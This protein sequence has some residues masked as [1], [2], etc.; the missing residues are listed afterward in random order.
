MV[1]SKVQEKIKRLWGVSNHNHH[2]NYLGLPSLFGK[3][4]IQA[5][6]KIK[7]KVVQKLQYWKEKYISQGVVALTI[8]TYS[9]SYFL[10]P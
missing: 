8:P 1:S 5:F 9:M 3:S 7:N 10:I 4:R 2:D 6:V